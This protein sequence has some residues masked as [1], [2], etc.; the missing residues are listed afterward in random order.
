MTRGRPITS[1]AT[2]AVLVVS[3]A[4]AGC[5]SSDNG[6]GN[7]SS[8]S[9]AAGTP[10]KTANGQAATIGVENSSLGKILEDTKGR[11]VY[12]FQK[13]KGTKSACTGACASA[14]PPVRVSG[15]PV[16]GT[17]ASASQVGTTKRSDGGRQVTYNGHPLYTYTGD[18]SPG[19]TNGQGLNAFGGGWFAL[20]PAGNQVSG[21]ASGSGGGAGGY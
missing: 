16:V 3:L 21:S 13:D 8:K 6:G 15:K 18:Q 9:G 11:T 5:G 17:G 7:S 2:A 10:P 4:A 20:S 12:L 19:D 1:L 14:W